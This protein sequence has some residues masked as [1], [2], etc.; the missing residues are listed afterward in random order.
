M[1]TKS[2]FY[3]ADY[4]GSIAPSF[5][6]YL[7]SLLQEENDNCTDESI[8]EV[9][10]KALSHHAEFC[11]VE[12]FDEDQYPIYKITVEEVGYYETTVECKTVGKFYS[13]E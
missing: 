3:A 2:I 1:E 7:C 9:C 11:A 13:H 4:E 12:G 5:A 8:E 6:A 10:R